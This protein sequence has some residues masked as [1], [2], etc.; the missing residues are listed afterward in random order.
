MPDVRTCITLDEAISGAD[1]IV[2]LTE[3][4]EFKNISLSS[5]KNKMKG[6]KIFDYRNIFNPETMN[7][8]GFEYY[9]LGS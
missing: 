1:V 8:L 3:W 2:I 4:D 9:C 6:N 7:K 5:L